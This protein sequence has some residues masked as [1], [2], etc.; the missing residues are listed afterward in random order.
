MALHPLKEH[1]AEM[2]SMQ[3]SILCHAPKLYIPE[4]LRGS[5]AGGLNRLRRRGI[6]ELLR[7]RKPGLLW[8][9]VW[10]HR[11]R[12]YLG[13]LLRRSSDHLARQELLC[14][15]SPQ[16]AWGGC[17]RLVARMCRRIFGCSTLNLETWSNLYVE[18][19]RVVVLLLCGASRARN[20][21]LRASSCQS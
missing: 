19:S 14:S 18:S 9:A 8:S 4:W 13:H 10:L 7:L 6:R 16:R 11:K 17:Q 5:Q 1:L 12:G 21:C 2:Q 15:M 3:L 20:Q